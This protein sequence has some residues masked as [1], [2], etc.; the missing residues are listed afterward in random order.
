MPFITEELWS[1]TAEQGAKRDHMLALEAWPQHDGLDNS[2]AEA[3]MGWVVDLITAIRSVRVEMNV[4]AATTMPLVLPKAS[5]QTQTRARLWAEFVQP[6]R[7]SPIFPSPMRSPQGAVQ[8]VV[9]GEVAALPL[10]G[11]IDLAAEAARLAKELAKADADI[12]RV[13]A[14]LGNPNFVDRAPKEVVEEEQEKR[15]EAQ[16]RRAKI[17]EAL[18]RLK[19]AT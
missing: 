18:D 15:A 13:D 2:E 16:A 19:G 17:I 4:P 12:A 11:V 10:K 8:L 9:R 6:S 7:A 1:V 3:E 5:P 14:E